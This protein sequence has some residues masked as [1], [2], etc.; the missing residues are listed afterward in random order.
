MA[1]KKD[2]I[3]CGQCKERP[4]FYINMCFGD[5]PENFC[6]ECLATTPVDMDKPEDQELVSRVTTQMK[7]KAGTQKGQLKECRVTLT[8]EGPCADCGEETLN[9][10]VMVDPTEDIHPSLTYR[11]HRC[12]KCF[13]AHVE[14][15]SADAGKVT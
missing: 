12:E 3:M 4:A 5:T 10:L 8:I 13:D 6:Q 11:Q 7:E 1:K 9:T 14:G 15:T 2:T